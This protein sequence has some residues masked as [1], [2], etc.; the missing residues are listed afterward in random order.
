MSSVPEDLDALL[1]L[2]ADTT[3]PEDL[4]MRGVSALGTMVGK[5]VDGRST[6]ALVD[7]VMTDMHPNVVIAAVGVLGRIKAYS[8]VPVL[9]DVVLGTQTALYE[10]PDAKAFIASDD[11]L[12]LRCAAVQALG[13]MMDERAI[14]PLMS[15]LNDKSLN[16]RLRLAAA[17]SLGKLGDG[18]AVTPLIDILADDREK[19]LYLKESAAK[20]LGMLGDIRAVEPLIDI[21]ESKKGFRDKFNFL[22][23]QVIEAIARI[24]R[25][26]RKATDSL[27]EALQD[28]APSIRLAAVEALEA[29]GE[30]DCVQHLLPMVSDNNDDVAR[31]AISALY[32]LGGEQALQAIMAQDNLPQFLR[33]EIMDYLEGSGDDD[34]LPDD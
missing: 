25:P 28:E 32:E 20:A 27:V 7:C 14:I 26:H 23:E 34:E 31:A 1:A 21:L 12:R 18:H 33:S 16:Y 30:T 13:R 3:A 8:G 9:I 22:K 2:V 11:S 6:L 15:I 4:R 24:G 5:Q 19:S 10:G 17:E 29:I